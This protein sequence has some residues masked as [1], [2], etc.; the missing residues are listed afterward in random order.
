MPTNGPALP[1][2]MATN[3]T[4]WLA[5]YALD[6]DSSYLWK[7]GV[8]NYQGM[9]G[10]F[11]NVSN[12][13][14]LPFISANISGTTTLNAGNVT[15]AN[16]YFYPETAQPQF[17]LAE[18][19][20]WQNSPVPGMA[21]FVNGQ[22]SDVLIAS[23]GVP[24]MVNG[25]AKLRVLNAYPGVFGYL[26]QYFTNVWQIDANGNMTT[27]ATGILSPYGQFFATQPGPV[28]LV[29]MPDI[30]TSQRGTG[31]VYCVS[32]NVDKN[33]DGVMDLS[34]N[35][36]DATSQTSPMIFWRNNNFDRWNTTANLL[37]TELEQDDVLP[38][39]TGDQNLDPNDPDCDYKPNGYRAIPSARDLEDFTRLWI[40]GVT[41]NL[42]AALPAGSTVTLSWA[43]D[44][45]YYPNPQS[46]N[47]AIDI[48]QA[49]DADGG[50]GYLTNETSATAQLNS[51]QGHYV[52][53]LA[54]SGS[55]QLNA[56]YFGSTWRGNHFIWCGV[57]NG[58]G[59]LMLTIAD[60]NSNVLAQSAVYIQIKDIK[61]MYE[62]WTVGDNPNIAPL[63]VATNAY[64]DLPTGEMP[65][66]YNVNTD[67]STPYILHVHGFNMKT[68][69]KDRFA[70]TEFKRLYWQGYQGRF[71]EFRWPTT[72]QGVLNLAT[73]FNL[74]ESNAWASA[75]ALLNLLNILNTEYPGNV[76]LTAHSHG[77]V[78]AGEALRLA[79][80]N[81]VVNTYIAMQGAIAAF[82]YDPTTPIRE[83]RL[84][85]TDSYDRYAAYWTNG[86]PCYFN[87]IQG[88]GTFVNFFNTN[89]Y[90]LTQLWEP[91]QNLKPQTPYHYAYVNDQFVYIFTPLYFP[92]DTYNIFAYCDEARSFALGAQRDVNG[93]FL[94]NQVELPTVWPP[95]EL[96]GNYGAH[97]W[98]SAE[99]RSDYAQR[100]LF[101][102]KVLE[103]F[104]LKPI[105][106]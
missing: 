106:P 93:A 65:F 49:T 22:S 78:V 98:H 60:A 4:R 57:S 72:V 14:G 100:W 7:I 18:Y 92:Q 95:D 73:A 5:S 19:D 25:Y 33:H 104:K 38:G 102:D 75:P 46:N 105:Q 37:Y 32:L 74:S 80:N 39:T 1:A 10:M 99:F 64:N 85:P 59:G 68:W 82:A 55:I 31:V 53:R 11:N 81:Q 28:A 20:F 97:V 21:N 70:E 45:D 84:D 71:G 77:N 58:T 15:S 6:S 23:V 36:P 29:T 8:T 35:G 34:W 86:A 79:G 89:D 63:A 94:G 43:D 96:A 13:Y 56:N 30:N 9:N 88:A 12:W 40:S 17:Q 76:Y 101:W 54:P 103:K 83:P 47:P 87:G 52:G 24:T 42:L 62:R 90:A 91:D 41:T 27:N 67:A 2:L 26:A 3:Q 50:I 61:D 44:W 69:E 51:Y 16:G 48:F 66:H